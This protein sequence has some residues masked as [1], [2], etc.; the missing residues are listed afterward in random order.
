M[1]SQSIISHFTSL[2]AR[3]SLWSASLRRS[4]EITWLHRLHKGPFWYF[5]L[6]V[7][8]ALAWVY[9]K[10]VSLLFSNYAKMIFIIL[11]SVE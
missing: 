11:I 9:I 1:T 5:S 8:M 4:K 2:S 10:Y 6:S 7:Y 3:H